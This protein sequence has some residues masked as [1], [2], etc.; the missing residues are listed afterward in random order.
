MSTSYS[1]LNCLGN[2]TLEDQ[3]RGLSYMAATALLSANRVK[4]T[5]CALAPSAMFW[6]RVPRW[7]SSSWQLVHFFQIAAPCGL[8]PLPNGSNPLNNSVELFNV[9]MPCPPSHL[10]I[11]SDLLSAALSY[12]KALL[13]SVSSQNMHL[14]SNLLFSHPF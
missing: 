10:Y 6:M 4:G 1:L 11:F 2:Q 8:Q 3:Q 13:Q 7:A 5:T 9:T 14:L 12:C